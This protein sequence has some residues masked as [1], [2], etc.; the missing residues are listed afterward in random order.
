[1]LQKKRMS[2]VISEN[3]EKDQSLS[4]YSKYQI[5][6]SGFYY[7][8]SKKYKMLK[9][10][11]LGDIMGRAGRTAVK[12]LLPDLKAELKLDIIVANAENIAHGKGHTAKTINTMKELGIRAFTGGNHSLARAEYWT[13]IES[14]S[15]TVIRPM[16]LPANAP[17]TGCMTIATKDGDILLINLIGNA[18][19]GQNYQPLYPMLEQLKK[20]HDPKDYAAIIID[21]HA[22]TTAEK[23][24]MRSLCRGWAS[25]LVGTHTHVPTADAHISEGLG[26]ISD[27]GM[28]GAVDSSLGIE[29]AGI[30]RRAMSG[31]SQKQELTTT[32]PYY[33]R[34]VYAEISNQKCTD[35]KLIQKRLDV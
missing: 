13:D 30:I 8:F 3:I 23:Y 16:N 24:C 28:C 25:V 19:T 11:I 12:E 27:I 6:R 20:E 18:F 5:L 2:R 1:M 26:Y 9:V 32:G 17:G 22:E 14:W 33:L 7:T 10:L 35:I 15:D 29:P 31:L 21:L 4:W 34:A